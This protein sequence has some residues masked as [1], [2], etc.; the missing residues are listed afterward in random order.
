MGTKTLSKKT[1]NKNKSKTENVKIK[2]NSINNNQI[3]SIFVDCNFQLAKIQIG[4]I[5]VVNNKKN[6]EIPSIP[7][8]TL[9]PNSL[10]HGIV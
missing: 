2:L 6:N 4:N 7:N 8:V 10:I 3:I 5:N 9:R 1:A